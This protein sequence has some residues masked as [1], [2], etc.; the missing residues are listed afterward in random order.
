MAGIPCS[1]VTVFTES[2]GSAPSVGICSQPRPVARQRRWGASDIGR[3]LAPDSLRDQR[4]LILAHGDGLVARRREPLA[5]PAAVLNSQGCTREIPQTAVGHPHSPFRHP[6][7]IAA[8]VRAF[9]LSGSRPSTSLSSA[10]TSR[11]ERHGANAHENGS[12]HHRL[13]APRAKI[14]SASNLSLP[15]FNEIAA[16]MNPNR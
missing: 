7:E 1:P 6:R 10:T 14:T 9:R 12:H 2:G 4:A 3:R 11:C 8:A 15:Q 16:R 13:R 5:C